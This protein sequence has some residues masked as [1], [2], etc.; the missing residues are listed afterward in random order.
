MPS[1][2][3]SST[4]KTRSSA[5]ADGHQT[6]EKLRPVQFVVTIEEQNLGDLPGKLA[7]SKR[8]GGLR[9]AVLLVAA[10]IVIAAPYGIALALRSGGCIIAQKAADRTADAGFHALRRMNA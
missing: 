1:L 10:A 9:L 3:D 4:D 8:I 6:V 5:L 2:L 7:H